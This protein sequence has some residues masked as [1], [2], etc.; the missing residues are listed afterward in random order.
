MP[1]FIKLTRV[2]PPTNETMV[3]LDRILLV[4][5]SLKGGCS[6][7]FGKEHVISFA[8]SPEEVERLIQAG[9]H[10]GRP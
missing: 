9:P 8:E 4:Q 3:N 6:I 2:G 1:I 5:P 7:L 10:I